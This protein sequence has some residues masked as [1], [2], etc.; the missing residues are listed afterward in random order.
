MGGVFNA[1]GEVM[2]VGDVLEASIEVT[3]CRPHLVEATDGWLGEQGV[4]PWQGP[5]SLPLWL[6]QPAHAGFTTRRNDAATRAG[7]VLRDLVDTIRAA[8]RTEERAGVG[9]DRRAGL[10]PARERELLSA[11]QA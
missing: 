4:E 11:L 10:T 9:R 2:T 3:G 5:E 6:P 8:L 1:V 7:L